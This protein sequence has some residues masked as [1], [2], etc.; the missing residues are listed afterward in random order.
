MKRLIQLILISGLISYLAAKPILIKMATLAPEGTDWHGFLVEMGQRWKQATNG[1]IILRIYPGGVV[2]DERDMIRKMRIGQIQAAAITSEGLSEINRDY[3]AFFMPL[4]YEDWDDVDYIRE[5]IKGDLASGLEKNGF[6]LLVMADVGFAYWF[7]K[8]P[9]F[10]PEDLK[11]KKIFV[12]AGDYE[13]AE[14][15]KRGGYNSV[16]LASTDV[17]SGLQT[18]LVNAIATPPLN[19]LAQQWFGVTTHMLDMRWGLLS[20]GI[21]IDNRTWKKIKPEYQ[22]IMLQI[23][24][25]VGDKIQAK[26]RNED[27]EAIKIMKKY[28]LTVHHLSPEQYSNW[29]ELVYSWYPIIRGTAVSESIFDKVVALKAEKQRLSSP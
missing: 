16:P 24:G 20:G 25:E 6:K 11:G 10:T 4:L 8:K 22:Q 28:G 17:L 18:G 29:E 12:W 21:V 14:L 7:T 13:T 26:N 9:M 1:D 3:T 15:W 19:A 5:R 2:G 23:A 27:Q